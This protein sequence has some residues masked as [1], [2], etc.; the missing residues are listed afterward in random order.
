MA[1]ELRWLPYKP[2]TVNVRNCIEIYPGNS[3]SAPVLLARVVVDC[4]DCKDRGLMPA[5]FMPDIGFA[6]THFGDFHSMTDFELL[7]LEL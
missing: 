4:S 1:R 5:F 3:T 6:I 7:C 2:G